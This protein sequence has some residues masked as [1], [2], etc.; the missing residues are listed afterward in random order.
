M[1]FFPEQYPEV[2]LDNTRPEYDYIIVGGGTAGCV[3]ANR[4][5]HNPQNRVLLVERGPLSDSWSSRVPLLSSDFASNGSRTR[6]V[7]STPQAAIEGKLF[8]IY[9]GSALGGS[10]RINQMIY[11][12]GLP[13]EYDA[14]REAGNPGW[15]WEDMKPYFIRPEKALYDTNP[16]EH[17][18]DGEWCN[19]AE[20]ELAFPGFRQVINAA[21]E[22][23]FPYIEDINASDVNGAVGCGSL[24]FTRDQ[25]QRRNST[26]HAF[27]PAPLCRQRKNLHIVTNATVSSL[28]I[29]GNRCEG[30]NITSKDV[31]KAITATGEVILSAGPFGSPHILLL[32]GIG[33]KEHLKDHNILVNKDLPGVGAHLQDHFGVSVGF[34][35]PM[36][37]SLVCL[38]RR[39]WI[40]IIE[41]IRY[42][43]WGTGLLLVPVLQ[44]AIFASTSHL[45]SRGAPIKTKLPERDTLPDVEIMPMAYDSTDNPETGRGMFSMLNVLLHPKS[46]GTVRL[47]SNNPEDP[48]IIDLRYLTHPDD[49]IPLRASVRLSFRLRDQLIAQGYP[50]K[51]WDGIKRDEP[52]DDVAIDKLILRRNRTT[53]HYSSTCRM[54]PEGGDEDGGVVNHELLVH[55]F[56]NLRVADSSIFPWVLGTHLQAP[57]VAVAEKCADMVLRK[58]KDI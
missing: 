41:L 56:E 37:H 3:L 47:S 8:G 24:H 17:G 30:V 19:R 42:L 38:Q 34:E 2:Q 33:P 14:W 9:T 16:S 18:H 51:D 22:L 32:S 6:K 55:G 50:L 31:K 20:S 40:F 48:L 5:S 53:Y 46:K 54:A 39:P 12:R 28:M 4:L 26:Y 21:E 1:R 11:A 25:G 35:V 13:A 7:L 58:R 45:D 27:L 36:R 15:G 43:I 52:E 44:T 10:S 57:V 49:F 23:G 29:N